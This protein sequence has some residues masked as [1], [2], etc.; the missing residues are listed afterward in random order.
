[1]YLKTPSFN[2][3]E[4]LIRLFEALESY[5]PR[6]LAKNID[7]KNLFI[8]VYP[9]T[10]FD[11]VKFNHLCSQLTIATQN[12]LASIEL[13]KEEYIKERLLLKRYDN[14]KFSEDFMT[15]NKN[16]QSHLDQ[17]RPLDLAGHYHDFWLKRELYYHSGSFKKAGE[18]KIDIVTNAITCLDN[19][20][21]IGKLELMCEVTGAAKV[22]NEKIDQSF[23]NLDFIS[24]LNLDS[25]S[26]IE[27]FKSLYFQLFKII[28]NPPETSTFKKLEKISKYINSVN[29]NKYE[30][31]VIFTFLINS[32]NRI[33]NLS[34]EKGLETYFNILFNELESGSLNKGGHINP[35]I[36]LNLIIIGYELN[37]NK[38]V[39]YILSKYPDK[40]SK[41]GKERALNLIECYTLFSTKKYD[42]SLKKLN[43]ITDQSFYTK[44]ISEPLYMRIYFEKILFLNDKESI[45]TYKTYS[46]RYKKYIKQSNSMDNFRKESNLQF[47]QFT[48]KL[49]NHI[50]SNKIINQKILKE[51]IQN[52]KSPLKI[53]LYKISDEVFKRYPS[54]E[55]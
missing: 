30:K 27:D 44:G 39:N 38:K 49:Y 8:K 55:I 21:Q 10:A 24:H 32:L 5:A 19:F 33:I 14:K 2:K 54:P 41:T 43:L 36:V 29:I 46:N 47:I 7:R 45:S 50:I 23:S 26:Q 40:M 53:W 15:E 13:R 42:E 3:N 37:K 34:P 31:S 20:Y 17:K 4:D 35:V 11:N 25:K 48:N 51:E 18:K 52:S 28:N 6:F 9:N 22:I 1:M 12:F 16:F